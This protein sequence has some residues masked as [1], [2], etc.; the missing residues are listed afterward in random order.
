[1]TDWSLWLEARLLDHLPGGDAVLPDLV[2]ELLRRVDRGDQAAGG[3]M[4]LAEAGIV[5]DARDLLASL[6]TIGLGVPA[7]VNSP[8]QLREGTPA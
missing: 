5:D 1:M 6:S 7:G 2:G 3:E 4:A 8:Y